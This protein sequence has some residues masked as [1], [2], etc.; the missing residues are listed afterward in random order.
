MKRTLTMLALCLIPAMTAWGQTCTNNDFK[1]T[2]SALVTGNFITPPPG[3]PAGPTARA[4]RVQ[5]DGNGN[6]SIITT[7]SLAGFILQESYGGT[8][9]IN[10]DCTATVILLIPFLGAPQP[11]PFQFQGVLANNGNTMNLL[12]LNPQGTDV[13]I[14][15]SKQRRAS[16]TN[17]DLNGDYALNL[18]GVI[19]NSPSVP[20]GLFARVGKVSFDGAG[21]FTA[22]VQTSYA[23]RL[24]PETFAG[25]YAMD[26]NCTFTT[27]F[28]LGF[29]SGW[30]GTF[31]SG[32]FGVMADTQAGAN[33]I[34]SAPSGAVVTGTLTSVR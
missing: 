8:Y 2:Y 11:V 9:T 16:C 7:L 25:T 19:I 12:L 30:F 18:A 22:A 15:L 17:G 23:G 32:W 28:S 21:A 26:K 1:G 31:A 4:G 33:L 34:Q 10:P 27:T 13:R 20:S 24:V 14:N 6:S 29:A 3:V 5:L